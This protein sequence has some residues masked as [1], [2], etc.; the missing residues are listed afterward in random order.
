[1]NKLVILAPNWLGDAVMALPAIADVRRGLS[2]AT[3]AVAARRGIAPLFE[4]VDWIDEVLVI[5]RRR[6]R[7]LG[8]D[9]VG[10]GFDTALV[11]PNSLH[12]ALL[13]SHAGI[14]ERWGYRTDWRGVLLTRAIDPPSGLHQVE[15]YQH[16]V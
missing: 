11:L 15:Y 6:W 8:V 10:R 12:A 14:P 9:L 7:E 2:G 13:A 16:L 1:M 5:E 3:I 4:M